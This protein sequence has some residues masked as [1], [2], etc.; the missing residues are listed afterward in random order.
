MPHSK[1]EH[2]SDVG[3]QVRT[4]AVGECVVGEHHVSRLEV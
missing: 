2:V 4:P 1:V 3:A